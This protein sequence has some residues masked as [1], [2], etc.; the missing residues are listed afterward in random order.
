MSNI[1]KILLTSLF[2]A[3]T[4]ILARF[5]SFKTPILTIGF[6]FIPIMLSGIILGP[7]YSTFIAVVAD[8]IGALLFPFGTFFIGYTITSL[9]TG[10]TY[11]LFLYNKKEFKINKKFI[12]KLIIS[13]LI[14]CLLLNGV[15]NT[16]WILM[17]I[18]DPSKIIVTTRVIKQLIMIPVKFITIL[19]LSK[20][21]ET[22]INE[23]M[24]RD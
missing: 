16:I 5:L 6:S 21:L 9:L 14:V 8:V 22:K 7:K 3:A 15:L 24:Y 20:L 17:T 13:T 23:V 4:I 12:I 19:G 1:K 18:S 2:I 10:L 11:G